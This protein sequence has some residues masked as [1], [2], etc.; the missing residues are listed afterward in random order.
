MVFIKYKS[1]IVDRSLLL[2]LRSILAIVLNFRNIVHLVYM[3]LQ[4]ASIR[5]RILLIMQIRST[6]LSAIV[7]HIVTFCCL[8][9]LRTCLLRKESCH[10]HLGS[11]VGVL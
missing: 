10:L 2:T 6:P 9:V 3:Q 8:L 11:N 5:L 1:Q 4:L 7:R